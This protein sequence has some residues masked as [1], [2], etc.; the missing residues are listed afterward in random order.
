M[1]FIYLSLMHLLGVAA[2]ARLLPSPV[3]AHLGNSQMN[4][5][6]H[7]PP[8]RPPTL[9][10]R[11]QQLK[12]LKQQ[13]QQLE[14]LMQGAAAATEE[15]VPLGGI[16]LRLPADVTPGQELRATLS[17]GTKLRFTAPAGCQPGQ[18]VRVAAKDEKGVNVWLP[19]DVTLGQQLSATLPDG[20]KVRLRVGA[21][22]PEVEE[23]DEED[24]DSRPEAV[25]V[26]EEKWEEK[27]KENI[28]G[29]DVDMAIS[30][31]EVGKARQRKRRVRP[32]WL[33]WPR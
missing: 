15:S 23:E 24:E 7:L 31:D 8:R 6:T 25:S 29:D 20:T 14:K 22:G 11:Q 9:Q 2:S 28:Q 26:E 18:V 10:Q 17:D 3:K 21:L 5:K 13:Q 1:Y 30:D 12:Q 19:A 4:A 33:R 32:R 16:N 27:N